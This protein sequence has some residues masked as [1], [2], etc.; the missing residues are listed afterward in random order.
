[1]LVRYQTEGLRLHGAEAGWEVGY[2]KDNCVQVFTCVSAWVGAGYS[3]TSELKRKLI[4]AGLSQAEAG[5]PLR[6]KGEIV[7]CSL[8]FQPPR[9][10]GILSFSSAAV[11]QR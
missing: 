8:I 5:H 6:I 3:V 11:R 4:T 1:M 9:E 2:R 10:A 7:S